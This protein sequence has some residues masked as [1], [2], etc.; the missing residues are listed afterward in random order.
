MSKAR[1]RPPT[2]K[3]RAPHK[4]LSPKK[5]ASI[6]AKKGWETRRRNDPQR[7]GR[8]PARKKRKP[9]KQNSKVT[10]AEV[11]KKF[12]LTK[13]QL[14]YLEEADKNYERFGNPVP[15]KWMIKA[16]NACEAFHLYAGSQY[17]W[18]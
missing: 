12:R 4:K 16:S 3:K 13:K 10:R 1:K 8:I 9:A 11:L 2:P 6:A 18:K 14:G 15:D 5:K 7:W 17:A